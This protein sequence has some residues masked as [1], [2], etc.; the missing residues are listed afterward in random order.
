MK[1]SGDRDNEDLGIAVVI[2]K[3]ELA[4][5]ILSG[6]LNLSETVKRYICDGKGVPSSAVDRIQQILDVGKPHGAAIVPLL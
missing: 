6:T 5:V 4:A 1:D 2:A 3:A